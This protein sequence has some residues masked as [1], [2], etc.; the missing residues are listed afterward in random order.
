MEVT[1]KSG[2]THAAF[3]RSGVRG[4]ALAARTHAGHP[5][6]A[7]RE[8]VGVAAAAAAGGRLPAVCGVGGRAARARTLGDFCTGGSARDAGTGGPTPAGRACGGKQGPAATV[9]PPSRSPPESPRG[10]D[11]RASGS[12]CDRQ[13]APRGAIAAECLRRGS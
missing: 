9:L 7:G 6:R 8:V 13:L 1:S 10:R 11:H 3:P 12:R 5:P 4:M 2:C